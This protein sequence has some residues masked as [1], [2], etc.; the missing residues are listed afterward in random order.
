METTVST[1][2]QIVI[3]RNIRKEK[4]I[5]AKDKLLI[6]SVPN[7]DYILMR[8]A[9]K[10]ATAYYAGIAKQAYAKIDISDYIEKSKLS[11]EK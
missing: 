2:H 8:P 11:W 7:S 3:P 10:N 4:N 1:K 9:K 6:I 5:K